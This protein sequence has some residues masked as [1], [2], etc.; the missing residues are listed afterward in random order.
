MQLN[1]LEVV[2][3]LTELFN[4][5]AGYSAINTARSALSSILCN[6]QGL[7]IGKFLSV[8]RFLKGVFE[9]R[10][11]LP[12][13]TFIW[14][15]NVVLEFLKNFYPNKDLPLDV[16]SYKLVMLI[17]LISAQR[18]QTL[19]KLRIDNIVFGN[20]L[21][22]IPIDDLLKNTTPKNRRFSIYLKP[23]PECPNLCVIDVLKTYVDCTRNLRKQETQLFISFKKPYT[24][25]SR[26]TI[27]RW[28][29]RVLEEAG[30]DVEI[31]KAHSTRAASCAK[32]KHDNIPVDD[33]IK[34]AGWSNNRTYKQF[35]DK[36]VM[37]EQD[38]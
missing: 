35:Y 10:P 25:V 38:C 13:Y 17:A 11:P 1:E 5:G 33:I 23:Y 34:T 37:G 8:K 9:L 4:R 16:L 22:V 36:I 19:H 27:S 32:A 6:D 7:S 14:D 12:R 29:R 24:A 31:F 26:D 30:I 21:V 3:F 28:L 2:K 15:A 20:D 18:A